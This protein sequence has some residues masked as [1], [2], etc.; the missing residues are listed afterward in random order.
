MM[1]TNLIKT[2]GI[3]MMVSLMA[4]GLN[5][6]SPRQGGR[7]SGPYGQGFEKR[8]A[9]LALDLSTEQQEAMKALRIENYKTLKPLKNKMAELKAKERTLLSEESV[10][11]KAV[12]KV[13]DE[14]TDL[15]NEM[16]KIQVGHKGGV[17]EILTDEQIMK[18][19]QRREFR[20]SRKNKAQGPYR[21][22]GVQR[23]QRSAGPYHRNFA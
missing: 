17:K 7:G 16:R 8:S 1:K 4:T 15:S 18:L 2:A 21:G 3:L 19:D 20:K 14:Q 5:A 10:D 9:H 6:Q 22:Q 13:I 12:N 23:G 11:L